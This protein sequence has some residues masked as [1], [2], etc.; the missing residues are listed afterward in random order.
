[1][2]LVNGLHGSPRDWAVFAPVLA[3]S[4]DTRVSLLNVRST[5]L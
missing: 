5:I 2:V 3:Q 1:V 4:Y